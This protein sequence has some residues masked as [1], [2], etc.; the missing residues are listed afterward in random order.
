MAEKVLFG[1]SNVYVAERTE[2]EGVVTYGTPVHMPGGVSLSLDPQGDSAKFF[3]DNTAFF[4]TFANNGYDADME[5]ANVPAFFK[6]GYLGYIV[7][8]AGKLVE[9]NKTGKSFALLFQT[10]TDDN[11][12]KYVLYNCSASRPSKEFNTTEDTVDPQPQALSLTVG[13][14]EMAD[15]SYAYIAECHYGDSEYAGF[16]TTAPTV[17]TVEVSA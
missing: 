6:T 15:G 9:T 5:V 16:F 11:A 17:P 4:A 8:S 3:A 14:D 1:L 13:G 7:D 2:T 10:E 12:I